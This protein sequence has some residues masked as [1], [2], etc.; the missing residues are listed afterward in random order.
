MDYA[1]KIEEAGA[2]ALELNMYY[3]PTDI[4][5]DRQELEKTYIDL[6]TDVRK[7][8]PYPAGGQTQPILHRP[9]QLCQTLVQAGA[10]G[11]VLFNRFIQ[12]DLD[13]E[14]L[15]VVPNLVLSTSE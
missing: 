12:P 3:M 13:I 11:L 8:D 15:E 6:V 14:T 10:N 1:K 4:R 9:A 7:T 2:D 5:P